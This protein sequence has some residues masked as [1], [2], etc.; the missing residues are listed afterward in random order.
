MTREHPCERCGARFVRRSKR[1]S[2]LCPDCRK[3]RTAARH[4]ATG[5]ARTWLAAEHAEEY[6]NL[7]AEHVA[8]A[9]A[10]DPGGSS[11]A[12]RN[13]ARS[14]SLAE[15]QRRHHNDY[16]RQYESEL[17]CVHAED[18][19]DQER[20]ALPATAWVPYWQERDAI[21]QQHANAN[22]AARLRALLWLADRDPDATA[23]LFQAQVARL[24]LN[25]ADRTPQRRRALAWAATVDRLAR[26]HLEDFHIRYQVELSTAK[27]S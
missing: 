1:E 18:Q 4:L 14:R 26:L 7:Y 12:I 17:A 11:M 16:R 24:P 20:T 27:M 9:R 25:P 5:R 13:R 8:K 21:A 10:Q 2:L 22:A 3:R 6:A 15:L 23:Q 19:A